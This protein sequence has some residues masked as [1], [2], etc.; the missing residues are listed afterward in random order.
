VTIILKTDAVNPDR[1]IL[2]RAAE[3]LR[4]RGTVA[5]PTETVYGLGAVV[6]YEDAVRKVFWAKMRPPDNPLIIHISS[7]DM[8]ET[9]AINIPEDAYRLIRRFWP[10]PLTLILPRNPSIPKIVTGG[11]DTVAVR[12][13]GHP[14]ALGLIEETGHP[15]AAPSAN[16][17]GKPSPTSADHVIRDLA[18]RIDAVIDAG[19]TFLGVESTVINILEDPPVLLR[20]GAYPVEEIEREHGKRILIPEYAR[21]YGY[22]ETAISPG[23][24]YRH[25]SPEAKLI[26]VETGDTSDYKEVA[27]RVIKAIKSLRESVEDPVCIISSTE[28]S[29]YYRA[30][31]GVSRIFIIGSR[32]NMY[33]VA[34]NLFKV[35]R[36]IDESGCKTAFTEGFPETGIGLAVMNRLRKAS[37]TIIRI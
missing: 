22:A 4:N 7:I 19:E 18:G 30:L 26:L 2:A 28:T 3:I 25:Y 35:L 6:Y 12:M 17:S 36:S 15:I 1:R 24:K 34:R 32:R 27:D 16:I 31:D 9:V 8:L 5:F 14:V 13:P 37:T 23:M 29:P 11:L 33:E 20:P 21:G 10:G